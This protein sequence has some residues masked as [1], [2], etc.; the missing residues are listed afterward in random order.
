MDSSF[1]K[2]E[3]WKS[4][5][6]LWHD[7]LALLVFFFFVYLI[8]ENVLSGVFFSPLN[9]AYLT[10]LIILWIFLGS[11]IGQKALDDLPTDKPNRLS[12]K[13]MI[14]VMATLAVFL[15]WSTLKFTWY[16]SLAMVVA[17][18]FIAYYLLRLIFDPE[19]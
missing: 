2:S 7:G 18:L 14:L 12:K 15:I 5:Y 17:G 9:L 13:L 6:K 19:E 3:F 16:E 10:V 11:W 1:N 8:A 4:A